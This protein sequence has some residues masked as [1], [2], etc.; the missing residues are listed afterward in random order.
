MGRR[1]VGQRAVEEIPI[2]L[3][4]VSLSRTGM[5]RTVMPRTFR[6]AGI[7]LSI[8]EFETVRE[9]GG[10]FPS[11]QAKKS[12]SFSGPPPH[13]QKFRPLFT[14]S[15]WTVRLTARVLQSQFGWSEF[16]SD[17]VGGRGRWRGGVGRRAGSGGRGAKSVRLLV[18]NKSGEKGHTIIGRKS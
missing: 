13:F 2:T 12:Q 18:T 3:V 7:I 10:R 9:F 17:M 1:S 8:S 15:F 5:R 14:P 4:D 16:E 11:A 6:L